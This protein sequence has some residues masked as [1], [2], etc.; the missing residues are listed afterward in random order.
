MLAGHMRGDRCLIII[1]NPHAVGGNSNAA[2]IDAELRLIDGGARLANG[3]DNAAPICILAGD[4]SLHQGRIGNRHCDA[5]CRVFI[6]GASH[7]NG[8]QF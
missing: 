2:D 8:D 4:G 1:I 6:R 7:I 5:M 3:H